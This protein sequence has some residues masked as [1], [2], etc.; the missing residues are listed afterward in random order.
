MIKYSII[1]PFMYNGDRFA[2]FEESVK[3]LNKYLKRYDNVEIIIHETAS[4][5]YLNDD[6]IKKYNLKYMYSKWTKPFHRA[7][8]L[9]VPAKHMATGN[10]FVFFDADLLITKQWV[11]ELFNSDPRRVRIGWGVMK[12]LSYMATKHYVKTGLL[13]NDYQRI[14]K[15]GPNGGAG[16]GINIIPRKIF[17]NVAGWVED[18]DK[19]YGGEDNYIH[20]KLKSLGHINQKNYYFK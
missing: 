1:I 11:R 15:P 12:N 3:C 5:R 13:M 8:A 9:N 16:G 14:R 6:F 17:F 19:G 18:N 20:F 7:W 4:K 2:I 10:V